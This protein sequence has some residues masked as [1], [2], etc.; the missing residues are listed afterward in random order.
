MYGKWLNKNDVEQE[1]KEY[2]KL[3]TIIYEG[4][5][6]DWLITKK[7]AENEFY[8]VLNDNKNVFG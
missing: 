5:F 6:C 7:S 1:Q 2:R 4:F 8:R 3:I